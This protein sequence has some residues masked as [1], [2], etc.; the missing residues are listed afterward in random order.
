MLKTSTDNYSVGSSNFESISFDVVA[1]SG[2]LSGKKVSGI[3][4][5][6]ECFILVTM[7]FLDLPMPAVRT[8]Q[9]EGKL[10]IYEN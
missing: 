7:N 6:F 1:F 2:F 9:L 5:A 3:A 4:A 8:R 10:K